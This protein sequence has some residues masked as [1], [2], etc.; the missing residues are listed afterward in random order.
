VSED[1]LYEIQRSLGR[2][3]QKIDSAASSLIAHTEH[4]ETVQKALFERIEQLQMS[5]ARQKGFI[6]ALTSLG[7]VIGSV[8]GYVAERLLGHN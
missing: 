2:I 7:A 3:E 5:H 4:D 1:V 6:T 8:S